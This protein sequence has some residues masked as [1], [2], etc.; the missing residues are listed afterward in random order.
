[1]NTPKKIVRSVLVGLAI[2]AA[3]LAVPALLA[4]LWTYPIARAY[5]LH[6]W[7]LPFSAAYTVGS[8]IWTVRIERAFRKV[9]NEQKVLNIVYGDLRI[10]VDDIER[11]LENGNTIREIKVIPLHKKVPQ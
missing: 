8:A 9:R 1:M 11:F 3:A 7:W 2:T 6:Y 5:A 4:Y 10:D